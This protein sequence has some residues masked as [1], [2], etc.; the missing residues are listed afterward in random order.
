MNGPIDDDLSPQHAAADAYLAGARW[1]LAERLATALDLE[2]GLNAILDTGDEQAGSTDADGASHPS[3]STPRAGNRRQNAPALDLQKKRRK[4]LRVLV[5]GAGTTGA[6]AAIPTPTLEV[7]K[8]AA[9]TVGDI[10]LMESIYNIYFNEGDSGKRIGV[11]G[12]TTMLIEA[13]VVTATTSGLAYAGAKVTMAILAE[14]LNWLPV[15]GWITSGVIT[16][17]TTLAAG[18]LWW[19]GC[20]SA[21][22]QGTSPVNVIK[23]ALA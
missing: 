4:A 20:D 14:I 5:S 17:S 7:P 9:I 3:A 12:V 13:G 21:L 2:A 16:S 1:E 11:D 22:Q 19:W 8:H 23:Q 6:A 15:I 18:A 10:A